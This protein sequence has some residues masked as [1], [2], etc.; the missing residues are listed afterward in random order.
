MNLSTK[1]L[2]C[3]LQP[4]G[5]AETPVAAAAFIPASSILAVGTSG[6]SGGSLT[7]WD[8]DR[9]EILGT[10]PKRVD[11]ICCHPEGMLLVFFGADGVYRVR[12]ED[13]LSPRSL[14]AA[15]P[16]TSSLDG[17]R[18]ATGSSQEHRDI[19]LWDTAARKIV[20][21]VRD[22]DEWATVGLSPDAKL[23][24]AGGESIKVW[25]DTDLPDETRFVLGA[26]NGNPYA[27]P[28]LPMA[29][30]SYPRDR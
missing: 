7:L 3:T 30:S 13:T 18:L 14:A 9:Q 1:E 8:V 2:R 4:P 19:L 17:S 29:T 11:G 6:E 22:V 10:V 26:V 16:A 15:G 20:R 21:S 5:D 27:A 25:T 23:V 12:I 28:S 24:A